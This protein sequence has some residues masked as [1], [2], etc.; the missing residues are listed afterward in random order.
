MPEL[1]RLRLDFPKNHQKTTWGRSFCFFSY[2][3]ILISTSFSK[4]HLNIIFK[5]YLTTLWNGI[6]TIFINLARFSVQKTK[7]I[8][9]FGSIH[10]LWTIILPPC[11]PRRSISLKKSSR[12]SSKAC[13]IVAIAGELRCWYRTFEQNNKKS[14]DRRWTESI[15]WLIFLYKAEWSQTFRKRR[16]W[17]RFE[18]CWSK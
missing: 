9:I 11:R 4:Q 2:V 16:G 3:I 12:P 18:K 17:A 15:D 5:N 14:S 13:S 6:R 7:K 1:S 10:S 8:G